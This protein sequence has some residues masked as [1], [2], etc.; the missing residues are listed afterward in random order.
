MKN[1]MKI[2]GQTLKINMSWVMKSVLIGCFIIFTVFSRESANAQITHIMFDVNVTSLPTVTTGAVTNITG[3]EATGGGNIVSSGG[4]SVTIRGVCW[5]TAPNPTIADSHTLDGNGTGSFSSNL[6]SLSPNTTCY[7]RAYATNCVGTGYGNQTTFK[8]QTIT[9]I[10][11]NKTWYNSVKVYPNPVSD[12]L[13][14][15]TN[16]DESII[17]VEILN[18][19]GAII[20]KGDLFQTTAIKTDG[21]AS[22]VYMLKLSDG[23]SL[24]VRK[25]IKE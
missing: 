7:I 24:E 2:F 19:F 1:K 3:G 25:I 12:E 15:E 22:G 8:T 16:G 14:I 9:E 21:F 11:E 17:N 18:S 6:T 4:E 13:I 5:S 23:K 20:F 10:N